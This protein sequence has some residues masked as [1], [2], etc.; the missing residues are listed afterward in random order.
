MTKICQKFF[1]AIE[2]C[3]SEII[4]E[5]V[6]E[7]NEHILETMNSSPDDASQEET[8]RIQAYVDRKTDELYRIR[9]YKNNVTQAAMGKKNH[10]QNKFVKTVCSKIAV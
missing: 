9:S 6:D 8:D 5:Y 4:Q 7:L 3:N 1:G 2:F 10:I